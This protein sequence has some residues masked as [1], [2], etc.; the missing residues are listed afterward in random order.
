V[1]FREDFGAIQANRAAGAGGR[2]TASA[3]RC[4]GSEESAAGNR[5]ALVLA[6][7]ALSGKRQLACCAV[8][9]NL[10]YA[11]VMIPSP[12]LAA[13]IAVLTLGCVSAQETRTWTDIKGRKLEGSLVKQD[14]ATVWVRKGDGKE[15]SIPK[16]SLSEDDRK[17]LATAVPAKP[18]ASTGARF[19]TARIDV[20]AWKQRPEGFQIGTQL[21]PVTIESDHFII[22]GGPKARP[23]VLTAYAEAAERL[24]IDMATDLP[25][26][27][28]AFE[29]R[30]M[31]ILLLEEKEAKSFA[32]WHEEH[33]DASPN[34]SPSYNL[35]TYVIVAFHIDKDLAKE[36]GL[37]TLGR[38]Y[39]LDSKKAEHT[40]KTW[41][42]RIHFL[43]EDILRQVTDDPDTNDKYSIASLRLAHSYHREEQVC[44]KIESEVS[45]GGAA[46]ESFRNGRNW[47]G[48]TKKLLKDG[49]QP[50]IASFMETRT[51]EVEPRDLGFGLG[52]MHFIHSDPARIEGF[53]K[54]L[55]TAAKDDKSPDPEA[56]AKGLGFDS[57]GALNKAWKDYMVS[58]AFQ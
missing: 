28:T 9:A 20:T 3:R 47:A 54:I 11:H 22:A 45:F 35:E 48:A 24:W 10:H 41:P 19:N 8:D 5:H 14:D 25:K 26:L 37:T 44:G 16:A 13:A 27:P 32:K 43:A 53:A 7:L 51:S 56:F 52:L 46:L 50:D 40:R 6:A 1:L 33:A 23:A 49:I 18:A 58:D 29:G 39:R 31:P 17:H 36:K 34:V 55:E 12:R 30:K 42:A 4:H 57:P 15:V 21:Y 2:C 38:I